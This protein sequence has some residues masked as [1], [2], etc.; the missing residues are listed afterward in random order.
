MTI[1]D[2]INNLGDLSLRS[3]ADNIKFVKY[4]RELILEKL[5]EVSDKETIYQ[6][7]EESVHFDLDAV[8]IADGF[9]NSKSR[10]RN[11]VYVGVALVVND[12]VKWKI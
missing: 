11:Y 12:I 1:K 7:L 9:H 6:Y 3:E 4:N 8:F 2:K 5:R 10:F